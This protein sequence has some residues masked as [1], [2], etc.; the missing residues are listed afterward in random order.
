M[1]ITSKELARICGVSIGT[2][3]RA[4]NNRPEISQKTREK[5]LRVSRDLG[6]RPHLVAR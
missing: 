5:I 2:V 6:Y 4:L 1:R 3:D